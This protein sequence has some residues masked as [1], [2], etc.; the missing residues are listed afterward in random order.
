M[1]NR[2][3]NGEDAHILVMRCSNKLYCLVIMSPP[4]RRGH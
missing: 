2:C 3:S 1:T 4:P